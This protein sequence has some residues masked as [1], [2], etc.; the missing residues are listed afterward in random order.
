MKIGDIQTDTEGGSEWVVIAVFR[1]NGKEHCSRVRR[2][3]LAH[4]V[5]A[6]IDPLLKDSLDEETDGTIEAPST[7]RPNEAA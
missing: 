2:N 5:H 6:R 1:H 7:T 3:S 4:V